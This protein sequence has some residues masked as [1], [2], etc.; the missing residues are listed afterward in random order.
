MKSGLLNKALNAVSFSDR[1]MLIMSVFTVTFFIYKDFDIRMLFGYGLLC[2]FLLLHF[3]R[4]L[5]FKK[6]LLM[7]S[8]S[9]GIFFVII[10]TIFLTFLRP[11]S[12]HDA[13]TMV[14]VMSMIICAGFLLFMEPNKKEY[15]NVFRVFIIA[16]LIFSGFVI[17]FAFFEELFWQGYFPILSRASKTYLLKYVNRGYSPALG[18]SFT[19]TDYVIMLGVASVVGGMLAKKQK[20][21]K[22]IS[23]LVLIA[24]FILAILFVG[25]RGE[26][27]SI[28]FTVVFVYF[29]TQNKKQLLIKLFALLALLIFA[30]VIFI[31]FLDELKQISFLS[32]YVMTIEDI[33]SGEDTSSGRVELYGI[34]L[35][36]FLKNPLFGIG[37]GSF[38]EHVP[39]EFHKLHGDAVADVH[40][41][42]LQFLCE[43]G[44]VGTALVL[45][46]IIYIF[47]KTVSQ[48]SRLYK[49]N[50]RSE[51]IVLA[52]RLNGISLTIQT[53][54][55]TVGFLDPCFSKNI[56]WCFFVISVKMLSSATRLE[57]HEETDR[58]ALFF[59]KTVAAAVNRVKSK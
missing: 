3:L 34:A 5:V 51:E 31:I 25:R 56:F 12:R 46:P 18:G 7:P 4:R 59:K 40:N 44:I 8:A 52:A 48:T 47:V 16:A 57:K 1:L 41:I 19:L 10:A 55:L 28:G 45:I 14:Y 49:N 54:F 39:A 38:S 53:F 9:E 36:I 58:F 35:S 29:V 33:L 22:E 37:W 6:A 27:L 23:P 30:V 43:I 11:A 42:Y 17:F 21:I 50:E 26:L 2:V 13:D 20:G 32:R 15:N 24:V